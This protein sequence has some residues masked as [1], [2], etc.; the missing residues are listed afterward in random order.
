M[1]RS[2]P[3]VSRRAMSSGTSCI[4]EQLGLAMMP[5]WAAASSGFTWETTSGMPGSMRHC[6]ELSMTTAPRAA[7]SGAST[8]DTS[9]PAEK[10]AISTPS[11]AA[12][13]ASWTGHSRPAKVIERPSARDASGRSS[14]TGKP[15]SAEHGHHHGAHQAGRADHSDGERP[16]GRTTG[17]LGRVHG[18]GLASDGFDHGT[19]DDTTW[20]ESARPVL[21]RVVWS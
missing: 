10:S 13:V 4:V 17:C 8:F 1:T 14:P 18:H 19:A 11:K 6:A 12:G 5:S 3:T 15:R 9:P 2:R 16:G 20:P 21:R 7:A